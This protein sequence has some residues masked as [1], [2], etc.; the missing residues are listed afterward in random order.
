MRIGIYT[1]PL[2]LNYGGILQAWALQTVLMRM[3]H[4]VVTFDPYPF[5]S[6]SWKSLPIVYAK[7]I[8]KKLMGSKSAVFLE[9]HVNKEYINK[10]QYLRPFIETHIRRKEFKKVLELQQSDYDLLIA[11]SDQVWRPKYNTSYGR[12]IYNAFFDFAENW[13]VKRIAYAA[14]F[15]TDEWEYNEKQTLRCSRLASLFSAISVR[16]ISGINLCKKYLGVDATHVLDPTMLLNRE[17]YDEIIQYGVGTQVPSGNLL[18]YL[19]DNRLE[20]ETLIAEVARTKGLTPFKTNFA[21][22]SATTDGQVQPPVEQWL[23]NF[24]EADFVVTD[25]F[26]ACVFSIIFRKP[27]VAIANKKR[28]VSRF[29]SLL[30]AFHLEDNLIHSA[31]EYHPDFSYAVTKEAEDSL[32]SERIASMQFLLNALKIES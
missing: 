10:S 9:K 19:L 2:R 5:L 31:S 25:S 28:G 24:K 13:N 1:Q 20:T 16:E 3:G 11:G 6:L 7:R 8:F 30:A 17:D 26:H 32:A 18:C 15:G 4:E 12:T 23:R 21:N 27:F 22:N 14:S 29:E